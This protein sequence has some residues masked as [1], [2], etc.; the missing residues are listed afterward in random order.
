MGTV[1]ETL[2]AFGDTTLVVRAVSAVLATFPGAPIL[3]PYR[4]MDDAVNAIAPEAS[5]AVRAAARTNAEDAVASQILAM[6]AAIDGAD[7]Q[8]A[9]SS[10]TGVE[11][12]ASD[13]VLKALG[14]AWFA[15]AT[16]SGDPAARVEGFRSLPAGRSLLAI[17]AAVD[18]AL[19]LGGTDVAR[20]V[21]LHRTTEATRWV[22]IG[23]EQAMDGI[24][25]IWDALLPTLQKVVDTAAKRTD[26]IALVL[27]PFVPGLV[28]GDGTTAPPGAAEQIAVQSDRMPIYKWLAARLAAEHAASRAVLG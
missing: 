11:A 21:S 2:R 28:P 9:R 1:P 15:H 25:P 20:M 5:D 18:V 23:G 8:L 17:W 6:G 26:P 22:A 10:A 19:P 4:T 12:Q 7:R 3:Q 27:A 13:A 24:G 14:L 16:G